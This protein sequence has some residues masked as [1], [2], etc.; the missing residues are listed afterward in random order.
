[1]VGVNIPKLMNQNLFIRKIP[2][3]TKKD[4]LL[5]KDFSSA[6]LEKYYSKFGKI[7]SCKVSLA[8]NHDSRGYGFVCFENPESASE[9]LK[10][11]QESE[12]LISVKFQPKNR[13]DQ[14][15]LFNNIYVKNLPTDVTDEDIKKLFGPYG[16][17]SS[18]Y[19]GTSTK[20]PNQK[21]YFICFT[22]PDN[23]SQEYGPRCAAKAVEELNG[24]EYKGQNLH[25]VPA[26]KRE[27]RKKEL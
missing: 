7:I 21:F 19:K 12:N 22:S 8:E 27:D 5:D 1:L 25:V 6:E 3:K 20:D 15:K 9:A 2:K 24:K 26:L 23:N 10:Y 4:D 11:T 16:N 14:R 18:L 17:I 13:G